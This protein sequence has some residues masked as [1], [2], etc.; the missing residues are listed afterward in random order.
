MSLDPNAYAG[1]PAQPVI[2][3]PTGGQGYYGQPP[4]QLAY[5]QQPPAQAVYYQQP[6]GYY[7]PESDYYVPSGENTS[8]H[9]TAIAV[10]LAATIAVIGVA[11]VASSG[12]KCSDDKDCTAIV[13]TVYPHNPGLLHDYLQGFSIHTARSDTDVFNLDDTTTLNQDRLTR[14]VN[15]YE[16][17]AGRITPTHQSIALNPLLRPNS[18]AFDSGLQ[19][20]TEHLVLT[21]PE[22]T[23]LKPG[24]DWLAGY[25]GYSDTTDPPATLTV[26]KKSP[27]VDDPLGYNRTIAD[28]LAT[29]FCQSIIS[30]RPTH[31][32]YDAKLVTQLGQETECNSEGSAA[33]LA[34]MGLTYEQY[35]AKIHAANAAPLNQHGV[36]SFMGVAY[37]LYLNTLARA[38]YEELVRIAA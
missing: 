3:P 27:A 35:V 19:P 6:V 24:N 13:S 16:Q 36:V 34:R 26:A 30:V 12:E 32:T 1:Y 21:V 31:P 15:F 9:D 33:E 23:A 11:A 8:G 18:V 22:S 4:H 7:P 37:P 14:L 38:D 2:Y 25:T 5:Y 29:E 17:N 28:V 10:T 20:A